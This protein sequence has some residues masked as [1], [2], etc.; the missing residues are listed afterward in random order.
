MLSTSPWKTSWEGFNWRAARHFFLGQK[1]VVYGTHGVV[2][3]C[4]SAVAQHGGAVGNQQEV[5]GHSHGEQIGR[6]LV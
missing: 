3:G 6:R 5:D 2:G 4:L 1:M